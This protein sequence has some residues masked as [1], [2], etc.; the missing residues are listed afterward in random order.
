MTSPPDIR[1]YRLDPD[2]MASATKRRLWR[3]MAWML[4]L[5]LVMVTVE[6]LWLGDPQALLSTLPVVLPL[7]VLALAFSVFRSFRAQIKSGKA[8]WDSYDLTLS[9]NVMRRQIV[10]LPPIEILRPEVTRIVEAK[11]EGL[12][13]ATGDRHRFIFIPEQVIGYDEVRARLAGWRHFEPPRRARNR[14]IV[15]G[16]S[17]VLVGSWVGTGVLRDI[18]LA[19][20]S[21]AVLVAAAV[22]VIRETLDSKVADNKT[23]ARAIGAAGF[24][25]LAPIARLILYL[26]FHM[27]TG[28]PHE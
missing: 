5:I 28:W 19:M 21:G 16:W 24:L 13:V 18:R 15:I 1:S 6:S 2:E 17:T 10:N 27:N 3:R 14:L 12:T 20:V 7:M 11:G 25:L 8:A 4:T 9:E 26:G 23:K 22:V